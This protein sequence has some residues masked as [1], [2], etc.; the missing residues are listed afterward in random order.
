M[1]LECLWNGDRA[2][3]DSGCCSNL[4]NPSMGS[5]AWSCDENLCS[6]SNSGW[7]RRFS[8]IQHEYQFRQEFSMDP[9]FLCSKYF[10]R[11]ST[12]DTRTDAI[13]DYGDFS[14]NSAVRDFNPSFPSLSDKKLYRLEIAAGGYCN[15]S[16][17]YGS[18]CVQNQK[19]LL[20]VMLQQLTG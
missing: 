8:K 5:I 13:R 7:Y 4:S 16:S 2:V 15:T 1:E 6:S 14:G 3:G 19:I 18:Q 11:G 9:Q 10:Y 20:R 12:D 17:Y